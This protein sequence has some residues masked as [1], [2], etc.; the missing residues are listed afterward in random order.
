MVRDEWITLA[1]L[2]AA[3]FLFVF[4]LFPVGVTGL[5][6]L[7]VLGLSGV[8]DTDTAMR[9]FS[10]PAIVLVGALY[11]VSASLIRTGVVDVMETRLLRAS[12]NSKWRLLIFSTIG[13]CLASTVLN[14][15]SIVVLMLP[16]LLSAAQ[17]A[18][19][20]P[21]RLLMPLSFAAILGGTMTLIGTSTN[22]LVSGLARRTFEIKFLDFLPVGAC[23]ATIGLIYMWTIGVRLLPSRP[24]V[25]SITRGR[26]FEY[27]TEFL[28]PESGVAVGLSFQELAERSGGKIRLLQIVRDEEV[29]DPL[30]TGHRLKPGDLIVL[31]GLPERIVMLR[32]ELGLEPLPGAMDDNTGV[33]LGTTF[34]EL[35]VTPASDLLG[36]TLGDVGLHRR[37]GVVAI[38]LQRRGS[39]LRHGI[40]NLPLQAGDVILVQG[41][42][43]AVERLREI[44]GFILLTGV[45]QKITVR[46]KAPIAATIMVLFVAGAAAGK[47]EIPMLA[48]AAFAACLVTRCISLRGAIDVINWNILFLLAGAIAL[49]L[50]L[51]RSGLAARVA[52]YAVD[53]AEAS[54]PVAVLAI[55]YL[56][57]SI[58]TEFVS[59][60]GAAAMMVPIAL[61]TA[62][63]GGWQ[64]EPFVFGV[65]YA[66][67]AS[68]STPIGY[69][70]N[71]FIYGPGGYRFT[72][73]IKVGAPLQVI[74]W[75]FAV[76][77]LPFFFPF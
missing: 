58:F 2:V 50:G 71:A 65:A 77:A 56:L 57:T 60:A 10:N 41:S 68:F 7:A 29:L 8:L 69:Q 26:L 27:V 18:N 32:R 40:T 66:A 54:G 20:P 37:F 13:A 43:P 36:R 49:G 24:T 67:S 59:N 48:L 6:I 76:I 25:S 53:L 35:V 19:I 73:F 23:F 46:R 11:V 4:E 64:P 38:A 70:T 5:C 30:L 39:H 47:M 14:N 42:P 22:V 62:D 63:Q 33:P 44:A 1:V 52:H 15:T 16:I 28:V 31:R 21:S 74:L 72:D 55:I 61:A 12:G 3:L 51:H 17:R 9:A 34:A 75:L 45:E